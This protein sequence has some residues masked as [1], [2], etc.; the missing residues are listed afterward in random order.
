MFN[1]PMLIYYLIPGK[2]SIFA[3]LFI[4]LPENNNYTEKNRDQKNMNGY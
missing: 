3:E 4:F 2:I 1:L